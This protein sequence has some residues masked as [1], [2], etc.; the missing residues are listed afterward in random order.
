MCFFLLFSL[1]VV[2]DRAH[3]NQ[4]GKSVAPGPQ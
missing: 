4:G 1:K 3:S 2:G